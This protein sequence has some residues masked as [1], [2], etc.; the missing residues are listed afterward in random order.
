M[1]PLYM[2]VSLSDDFRLLTN[3]CDKIL[4]NAYSTCK[5][6]NFDVSHDRVRRQVN[7]AN[8]LA[9]DGVGRADLR[10]SRKSLPVLSRQS[11][12]VSVLSR[13]NQHELCV[14]A[15]KFQIYCLSDAG[16]F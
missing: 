5:N 14:Y 7:P 9:G 3:S 11:I 16:G 2:A 12:L 4:R 15:Q 6:S 10:L 8:S 13:E 1:H